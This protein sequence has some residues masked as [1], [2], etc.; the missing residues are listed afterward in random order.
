MLISNDLLSLRPSFGNRHTHTHTHYTPIAIICVDEEKQV[1]KVFLSACLSY[2]RQQTMTIL[3][4]I[5]INLFNFYDIVVLLNVVVGVAFRSVVCFSTHQ[6]KSIEFPWHSHWWLD[7]LNDFCGVQSFLG[8][9]FFF[10][11]SLQ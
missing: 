8:V 7:W 2:R 1:F 5:A 3:A 11:F 6:I 10:D 4:C 9:F